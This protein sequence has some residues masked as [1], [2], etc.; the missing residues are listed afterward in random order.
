M[1]ERFARLRFLRLVLWPILAAGI[2][3]AARFAVPRPSF[4]AMA[5]AIGYAFYG[6]LLAAAVTACRRAGIRPDEVIGDAPNEPRVWLIAAILAP[7]VLTFSAVALMMTLSLAQLFA[8]GWAAQQAERNGVD[9]LTRIGSTWR[10]PLLLL[11][12]VLAP[13]VEE[14][15]FRGM[16]M[17][18]WAATRGLW[19]GILGSAA[20][21]ALLHPPT[22]IGAFVFGVVA[23]ILYLWSGS[24]LAPILRHVLNNSLVSL[25]LA[26]G[27]RTPANTPESQLAV[28]SFAWIFGAVMLALLGTAI[29][30]VVRPLV[31]QVRTRLREQSALSTESYR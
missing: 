8:P 10:A 16:L 26:V 5:T 9:L 3:I 28:G 18:R 22:W 14:F 29:V 12:V 7:L 15:A 23:G 20:V 30:A 25:A 31:A 2:V 6:A 27:N 13:V 19:T 17:K 24:L 1:D 4:G 11:V 21:F